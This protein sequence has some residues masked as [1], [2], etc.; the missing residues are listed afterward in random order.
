MLVFFV[1]SLYFYDRKK[2]KE[3]I[4]NYKPNTT[5]KSIVTQKSLMIYGVPLAIVGLLDSLNAY[6]PRYYL[7]YEFGMYFVGIFTALYYF[8]VAGTTFVNAVCQSLNSKLANALALN[9][10]TKVKK[11]YVG[12]LLSGLI[13]GTLPVIVSFVYGIDILQF[14]Y[15][16]DYSKYNNEFVIILI[17]G[18][19]AYISVFA[20]NIIT[21]N[22]VVNK[23]PYVAMTSIIVTVI[24]S[25]WLVPIEPVFGAAVAAVSGR[26]V[27]MLGY[28]SI[29]YYSKI[30]GSSSREVIFK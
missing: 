21:I 7:Q 27:Q 18:A 13:I 17:A 19:F 1:S 23:Q 30:W 29:I 9:N 14:V 15:S 16:S 6:V 12:Y 22:R 5:F 10:K 25:F 4:S 11:I 3:I 20:W 24:V 26:V 2:I 8:I 28:L